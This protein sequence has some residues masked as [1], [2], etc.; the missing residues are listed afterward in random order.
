MNAKDDAEYVVDT[1]TALRAEV[2]RLC[3]ALLGEET[4]HS[5]RMLEVERLRAALTHAL[6]NGVG[7]QYCGEDDDCGVYICCGKASYRD[8]DADCWTVKAR[9]ALEGK[10]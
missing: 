10:P 5:K 4:E 7:T 6:N 3:A 2:E 8:H 9:A 1:I